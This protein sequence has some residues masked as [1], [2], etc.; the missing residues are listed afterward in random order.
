M[1]VTKIKPVHSTLKAAI[2]YI[3]NPQ[4]TDEMTLVDSYGCVPETAHL[5]FALTADSTSAYAYAGDDDDG[6]DNRKRKE[7]KKEKHPVLA[8]HVIQSFK[9]DEVTKEV[10]HEIGLEF[11]RT[12]TDKSHEY[13]VATHVDRHHIHNHIIF[14]AVNFKTK[15]KYHSNYRS[16]FKLRECSDRLCAEHGLSVITEPKEKG[17][18]YFEWMLANE[19]KSYKSALK[20]DLDSC[21]RSSLS[22]DALILQMKSLG[23]DVKFGKHIAFKA[24]GADRFTRTKSLGS[25]YTEEKIRQRINENVS[26]REIKEVSFS[27]PE[28]SSNPGLISTVDGMLTDAR[29][30]RATARSDLRKLNETYL[31]LKEEKID[32]LDELTLKSRG[33]SDEIKL[34]RSKI[35]ELESQIKPYEEYLK[36]ADTYKEFKPVYDDYRRSGF[37]KSFESAHRREIMLFELAA[38]FLKHSPLSSSSPVRLSKVKRECNLLKKQIDESYEKLKTLND[39]EKKLSKVMKNMEKILGSSSPAD[40]QLSPFGRD[41]SKTLTDVP[42]VNLS[43]K[44]ID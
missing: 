30:S 1:A 24:P 38:S 32:S 5:E 17:K 28:G 31:F 25:F 20:A 35:R 33:N 23:Y 18:S 9:P 2:K 37:D 4:K 42:E 36:Y 44:V 34:I 43:K 27:S 13:I 10:A 40:R 7:G 15:H 11:A 6:A 12:I 3:V 26:G 14:N 21:I 29:L 8:F 22:F 41:E 16:Y 19:G 39:T